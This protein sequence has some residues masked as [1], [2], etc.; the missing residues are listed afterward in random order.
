M[1]LF[2]FL[3]KSRSGVYK[4]TPENRKLHR[5]GQKYVRF[6]RSGE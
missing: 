3:A 4:D 1:G 6:L 5:V 2:E